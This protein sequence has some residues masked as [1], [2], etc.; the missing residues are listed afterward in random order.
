MKQQSQMDFITTVQD[1]YAQQLSKVYLEF[2]KTVHPKVQSFADLLK[3]LSPNV[4]CNQDCF[5]NDYYKPL[6]N[7][8][9][10]NY[11]SD[12][13]QEEA[14]VEQIIADCGCS[15]WVD[16][17]AVDQALTN[18]TQESQILNDKISYEINDFVNTVHQAHQDQ[19]EKEI[20]F[21]SKYYDFLN[22]QA[23]QLAGCNQTCVNGCTDPTV[24]L[25]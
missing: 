23:V 5:F 19:K 15:N 20:Q 22:K 10:Y 12:Q 24:Y 4:S 8:N 1:K 18:F 11:E 21:T 7:G 6:M 14:R 2:G 3:A 16:V 9:L 13:Q 25:L 17:D